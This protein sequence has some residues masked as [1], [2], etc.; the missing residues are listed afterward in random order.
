MK[1]PSWP[2]AFAYIG[3]AIFG[4]TLAYYSTAVASAGIAGRVIGTDPFGDTLTMGGAVLLTGMAVAAVF[5][6]L[7]WANVRALTRR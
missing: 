5:V 2:K 3:L 7:A 6:F 4:L 1:N